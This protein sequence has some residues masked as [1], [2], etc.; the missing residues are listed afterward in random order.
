MKQ[1]EVIC[2]NRSFFVLSS[3]RAFVVGFPVFQL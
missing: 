1:E 2:K 3:F